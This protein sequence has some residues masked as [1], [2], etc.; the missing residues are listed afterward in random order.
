MSPY[1][2]EV[3]ERRMLAGNARGGK[4]LLEIKTVTRADVCKVVVNTLHQS[5]K[6]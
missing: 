2:N 1:P 6:L 5:W 4:E 3:G